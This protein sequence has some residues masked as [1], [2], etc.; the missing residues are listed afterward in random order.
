MLVHH[1]ND[2]ANLVGAKTAA[3]CHLRAFEP[4]LYRRVIPIDM[5][6]RR[7]IRLMAIEVKAECTD[8]QQGRHYSVTT[9]AGSSLVIG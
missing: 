1:G 6:V 8:T 9:L 4:N 3:L 2:T 7:L 5:D